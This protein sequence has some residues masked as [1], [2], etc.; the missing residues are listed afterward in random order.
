MSN[1]KFLRD[2]EEAMSKASDQKEYFKPR[3][4]ALAFSQMRNP[5]SSWEEHDRRR[6]RFLKEQAVIFKPL[7]ITPEM[8]EAWG[9]DLTNS[10]MTG[11]YYILG[12]SQ[13]LY[14]TMGSKAF[15]NDWMEKADT[16]L[17]KNND[18][19]AQNNMHIKK[20]LYQPEQLLF[21]EGR[22]IEDSGETSTLAAY[23][24]KKQHLSAGELQDAADNA[25]ELYDTFEFSKLHYER[26]EKL[27]FFSYFLADLV[28][29]I[30]KLDPGKIP[31][32]VY[33][34][35]AIEFFEEGDYV[36]C[37][38]L[39]VENKIKPGHNLV[40]TNCRERFHKDLVKPGD[41]VRYVLSPR[42]DYSYRGMLVD[43]LR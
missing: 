17:Y 20:V 43:V 27:N 24:L 12:P 19:K 31:K 7:D 30:A 37:H 5:Y 26:L 33:E 32:E 41:L 23:S 3:D 25:F 11:F 35:K 29:L 42:I 15:G 8:V 36:L 4:A 39:R 18:E 1:E 16:W 38:G 10:D 21:V 2:I 9:H 40:L 28:E 13:V 6:D 14:L 22:I 34:G